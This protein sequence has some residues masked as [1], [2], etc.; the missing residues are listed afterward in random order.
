MYSPKKGGENKNTLR[1]GRSS[2]IEP[3]FTL[4]KRHT[5][6][7]VP[8]ATYYHE[9]MNFSRI[10]FKVFVKPVTAFKRGAIL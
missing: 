5:K 9:K 6:H 3:R 1:C 4:N 8:L 10:A 2:E 7:K